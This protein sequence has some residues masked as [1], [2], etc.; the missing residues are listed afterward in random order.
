M[1]KRY[2]KQEYQLRNKNLEKMGFSSMQSYLTST[3]WN[4]A[5]HLTLAFYGDKCLI[6]SNHYYAIHHLNYKLNTLM[7]KNLKNIVSNLIPLCEK[8][9]QQ[10]HEIYNDK[11]NNYT[12]EDATLM[13]I[14]LSHKILL[15]KYSADTKSIKTF[16]KLLR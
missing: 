5:K 7:A 15:K 14:Y 13:Q 8:C 1:E 16:I 2:I 11:N 9:H 3:I 4:R 6:C 10:I 12:I